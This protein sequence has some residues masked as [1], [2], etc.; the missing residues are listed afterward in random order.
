MTTTT[1]CLRSKVILM[2]SKFL[3]KIIIL[4]GSYNGERYIRAQI[5]SIQKQDYPDWRLIIR[6]DGSDDDTPDIIESILNEDGRIQIIRDELG[7]QGAIGNF[8]ILL[9]Y[10]KEMDAGYVCFSDQDDV[11]QTWK[12]GRQ[13]D[14]MRQVETLRGNQLPILVHSDLSVVDYQLQMINPSFMAFQ[15]IRH[16]K[17]SPLNVLLAQ[18][19]V[20]GCTVLINRALLE[21]ALPIPNSTLMHDWWLALCAAACG[22]LAFLSDSTVFYRQHGKNEVGAKGF[23]G[24]LNPF[25]NSWIKMWKEGNELFLQSFDQV[26]VL[27]KRIMERGYNR[28]KSAISLI[29]GY[30]NVW[31]HQQRPIYRVLN[32][33]RLGVHRQNILTQLLFLTRVYFKPKVSSLDRLPKK[34]K[35]QK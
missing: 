5:E 12:L 26:R 9:Q 2:D 6:D 3:N 27:Q 8:G 14:F 11:W 29:N 28:N 31:D 21:L 13:M 25:K 22:E 32:I 30:L 34:R 16:E 17:L 33:L 7:N 4:L 10:A 18:N 19:Y 20:T 1:S 35:F 24:M 15:R 23:L